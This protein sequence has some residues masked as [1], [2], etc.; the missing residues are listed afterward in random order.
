MLTGP[1]PHWCDVSR[2]PIFICGVTSHSWR[3]STW[4]WCVTLLLCGWNQSVSISCRIFT[5][6]F[7][8]DVGLCFP[9]GAFVGLSFRGSTRIRQRL[10]THLSMTPWLLLPLGCRG[11]AALNACVQI[12]IPGPAFQSWARHPEVELL[13]RT[14]ICSKCWRN[15]R[16][17]RSTYLLTGNAQGPLVS[18]SPSTLIFCSVLFCFCL[19]WQWSQSVRRCLLLGL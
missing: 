14:L 5:C 16:S 9:C 3:I 13:G 10:S 15:H 6:L 19:S 1:F 11:N 2:W 8:R 12:C 18:A 7:I 17:G 4:S